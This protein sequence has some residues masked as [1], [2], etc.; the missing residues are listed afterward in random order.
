MVFNRT[1]FFDPH[2]VSFPVHYRHSFVILQT[3]WVLRVVRALLVKLSPTQICKF[4]IRI[5]VI[6]LQRQ[7]YENNYSQSNA[8]Q[9]FF[10]DYDT[11]GS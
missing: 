2:Y 4:D 10:W 8:G 11:I 1:I 3:M 5:R 9:Y 7:Q 6:D